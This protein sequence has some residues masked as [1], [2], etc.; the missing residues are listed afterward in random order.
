M[1]TDQSPGRSGMT[2][3]PTGTGKTV[4]AKTLAEFLFGSPDRMIWLGMSEFQTPDSVDRILGAGDETAS[5]AAL[6]NAIRKQPWA[7]TRSR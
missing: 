5:S 7:R 6:V 3:G 4:I 2:K 1:A